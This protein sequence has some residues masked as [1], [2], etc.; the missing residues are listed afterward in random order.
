MFE[1][2]NSPLIAGILLPAGILGFLMPQVRAWFRIIPIGNPKLWSI[3][4]VVVGLIAGGFAYWSGFVGS[5]TVA[6]ITGGNQEEVISTALIDRCDYVAGTDEGAGSAISVRA[7]PNSRNNVYLDVDDS[8]WTANTTS[9]GYN[10]FNATWTCI[11]DK[12]PA[13][14]TEEVIE[15]VTKGDEFKSEVS[16]TD[17][18]NY[19]LLVTSSTPST[20][21]SGKYRQTA[22]VADGA[23]ATTSSTQEYGYVSYTAGEKS[24]TIGVRIEIDPTSFGTLNNYTIKKVDV[25]QRVDGTDKN[26]FNIYVNKLP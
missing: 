1:K 13:T 26:L 19:N 22:Y 12:V 25:S 2:W 23:Y 24:S 3:I 8:L 11:I 9:T 15:F 20:I 18:A 4:F 14:G 7:D 5:S 6:S 16:T 21:F 17:S 10:E